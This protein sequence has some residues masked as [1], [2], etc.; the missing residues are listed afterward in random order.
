V[1]TI[2]LQKSFSP[3]SFLFTPFLPLCLH[4]ILKDR[5]H[6][7]ILIL[8]L[9]RGEHEVILLSFRT[10]RWCSFCYSGLCSCEISI[11]V[12][13]DPYSP[14]IFI[15]RNFYSFLQTLAV[16]TVPTRLCPSPRPPGLFPA[17]AV[18]NSCCGSVPL[19]VP[20]FALGLF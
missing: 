11:E 8:T 19:L 7:I 1:A 16:C 2:V 18:S 15:K 4:P 3:Q 12:F 14:L 6:L 20:P 13:T 10:L 17:L 5:P 9:S